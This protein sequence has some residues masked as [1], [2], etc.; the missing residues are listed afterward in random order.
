MQIPPEAYPIIGSIMVAIA[1]WIK[2][3][4]DAKLTQTR[5]EADR[6]KALFK[7]IE[8]Q[9]QNISALYQ[10]NAQFAQFLREK[11]RADERNYKI[12]RRTIDDNADILMKHITRQA[13]SILIAINDVPKRLEAYFSE[14]TR[15][16]AFTVGAEIGAAMNREFA[17]KNLERSL[18]PF[19]D[20]EDPRWREVKIVPTL[21]DVVIRKEPYFD[22]NTSKLTKPCSRIADIGERV[23]LIEEASIGAVAVDKVENGVRCWGWLPMHTVQIVVPAD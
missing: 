1:Y 17:V 18:H 19:P 2:R 11:E 14:S 7:M 8:G 16:I 15:E 13:Q 3:D 4:A 9:Q 23:K 20:A 12:N 21:P 10:T 6:S 22:D 5:S